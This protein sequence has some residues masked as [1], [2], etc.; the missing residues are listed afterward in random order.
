MPL[1]EWSKIVWNHRLKCHLSSVFPVQ[2]MTHRNRWFTVPNFTFFT[3]IKI[4]ASLIHRIISRGRIPIAKSLYISQFSSFVRWGF[5]QKNPRWFFFGL[6]FS[7][8]LGLVGSEPD[9]FLGFQVRVL[10]KT[11]F[12]SFNFLTLYIFIITF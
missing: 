2:R 5:T 1:Y 7:A 8:T 12:F 10:V 3:W 4:P 11:F 9:F 6:I